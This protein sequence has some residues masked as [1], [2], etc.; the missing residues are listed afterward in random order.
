MKS[1]TSVRYAY[2]IPGY[3]FAMDVTATDKRATRRKIKRAWDLSN[4]QMGKV[5]V[6]EKSQTVDQEIKEK[7]NHLS[8]VLKSNTHLALTDF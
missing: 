5:E 7:E 8:D 2:T 4:Y 1:E 3:F 6:W